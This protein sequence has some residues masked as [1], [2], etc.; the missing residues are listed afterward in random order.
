MAC[1][2]EPLPAALTCLVTRTFL[3]TFLLIL[4]QLASA[5]AASP[6]I[7][8][9]NRNV[10]Q[11]MGNCCVPILLAP[12]STSG[13]NLYIVWTN[14]D[15]GHWSV[16]FAKSADGGKTFR[17]SMLT[18]PIAAGHVVNQNAEIASS[19][20]SVFVTWWT[21]KTGTFE[22]VFRASIDNGNTFEKTIRL[23]ST[24]VP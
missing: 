7:L 5:Y 14:N 2:K 22:P 4:T 13:N 11:E 17:T 1:L 10:E 8:S 20:S 24:S 18:V 19:G 21:N 9:N 15:T 3:I 6:S 12:I 16:F 23:N